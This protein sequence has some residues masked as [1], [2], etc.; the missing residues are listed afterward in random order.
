MKKI[1]LASL[2]MVSMLFVGCSKEELPAIGPDK[3]VEVETPVVEEEE[4][5]VAEVDG[6]A[7]TDDPALL[8]VS[9]DVAKDYSVTLKYEGNSAFF[10][11]SN[12]AKEQSLDKTE[13]LTLMKNI[14]DRIDVAYDRDYEVFYQTSDYEFVSLFRT[15]G[16]NGYSIVYFDEIVPNIYEF[17]K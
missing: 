6:P 5:V 17:V 10:I 3:D 8:Q 2:L 7:P 4:Q 14:C 13:I 9:Q 15:R 11:L 12:K 1:V 16:D